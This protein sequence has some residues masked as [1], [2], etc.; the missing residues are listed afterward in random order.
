MLQIA[1]LSGFGIT[2]IV[3][4]PL[5]VVRT[6]HSPDWIYALLA[7]LVGTGSVVGGLTMTARQ[8]IGPRAVATCAI[9]LSAMLAIVGLSTSA[10]IAGL[11]LFLSGVF[12]ACAIAAALATMQIAA[13][14]EMRGRVI[15][16]YTMVF[17]ISTG[18][19]APATGFIAEAT[20]PR[21]GYFICASVVAASAVLVLSGRERLKAAIQ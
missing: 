1:A 17:T 20:S 4:L 6:L 16:S 21:V 19:V 12:A 18:L 8:V 11:P 7:G 10:A 14:P 13:A 9:G 3:L 2:S 15:A 5:F